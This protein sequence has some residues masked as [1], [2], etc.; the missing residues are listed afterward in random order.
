MSKKNFIAMA[1][2]IME[3]NRSGLEP[4]S[5]S[6]LETLAQFCR[7]QNYDFKWDRW[8]SYIKGE[9]GKNGGA[10]EKSWSHHPTHTEMKLK[11]KS[12]ALYWCSFNRFEFRMS[13]EAVMD[14]SHQGQCDE[15]VKHWAPLIQ[16]QV[17]KD[18]FPNKPTPEK[19]REEL[20]EYGSW[21]E[22][23]LKDDEQN[24]RRLIWIAAGNIKDE[25]KPDSSKPISGGMPPSNG[26][27][28]EEPI[29]TTL[30]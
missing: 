8:M 21:D 25:S 20:G 2:A 30:S 9:C 17:E 16:K 26:F 14:C 18:N 1:D 13:G 3:H 24:W 22:E 15:D 27:A 10:I 6:Q 12:K 5:D 19:I 4:F 28:E 23:E 29:T 11:L 7:G